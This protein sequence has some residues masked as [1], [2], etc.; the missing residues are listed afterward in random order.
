MRILENGILNEN[1]LS[2]TSSKR[3]NFAET[4]NE[5]T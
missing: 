1:I 2:V 5:I 3:K 4:N